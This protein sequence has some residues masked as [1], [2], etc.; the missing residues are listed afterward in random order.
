M[1]IYLVGGAIRDKLLKRPVKEKDWVVVGATPDDML[2]QGYRPVGKDFPVFLHPDTNEEYALARTERKTG[3]GYK[4]FTCDASTSVTLEE[5]LLRRDLTIN[6]IAEDNQGHI[7]DPFKGQ[8]DLNNK[9]LR[10][11]SPAFAEDPVRVLRVARFAARY[12]YL[13]F[14]IAEQTLELMQNMASAGELDYLVPER[15]WQELQKA[16]AEQHPDIFF[17][18]LRASHA[19][20]IIIPEIDRLFGVPQTAEHHPEIDTGVHTLMVL[21]QASLLSNSTSVRFAALTHDLGKAA[22]PKE[23]WPRHIAHEERGAVLVEQMCKRLKIPNAYKDLAVLVARYHLQCHRAFELRANTLLN[24]F[25][26]A[27]AFRN[28]EKFEQFLLACE[29]DARGRK[30]R[31]QNP[32][33]QAA[34]LKSALASA[35][36]VNAKPFIEQGLQGKAIADAMYNTRCTTL[37]KFKQEYQNRHD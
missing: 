15:V 14:R 1:Q 5:D 4:G 22:T 9:I 19:L 17:E 37:K 23:E 2:A 18:T 34:Y 6:A 32:Y 20:A 26:K 29:A 25:E 27:G 30:G 8:Q 35:M 7:I 36:T 10:H 21:Q 3:T 16:L 12:A 33:P 24:L 11:V 28:P 31:E 13:G